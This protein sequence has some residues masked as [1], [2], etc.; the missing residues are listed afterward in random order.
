MD[1]QEYQR[2]LQLSRANAHRR[3]S[4]TRQTRHRADHQTYCQDKPNSLNQNINVHE[5]CSILQKVMPLRETH[6]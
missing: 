1:Y 3:S 4:L 6:D 2:S 5:L